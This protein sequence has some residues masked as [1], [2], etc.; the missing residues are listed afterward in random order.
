MLALCVT[1]IIFSFRFRKLQQFL[2]GKILGFNIDDNFQ[3]ALDALIVV[4]LY[5]VPKKSLKKF[6]GESGFNR[7]FEFNKL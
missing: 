7:Y 5:D 1:F 3:N 2:N 4:D 6:L